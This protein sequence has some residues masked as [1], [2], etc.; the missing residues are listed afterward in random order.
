MAGAAVFFGNTSRAL[1]T[2]AQADARAATSRELSAAA[3]TSLSVDPERAALLALRA[4]DATYS[5]RWRTRPRW[6]PLQLSPR[7]QSQRRHR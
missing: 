2:H 4:V 1:A 5:N 3:L 7:Q 6:P